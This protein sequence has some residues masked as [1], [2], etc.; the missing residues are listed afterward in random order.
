MIAH[1]LAFDNYYAEQKPD[2]KL[3]IV[4]KIGQKHPVAMIGDGINDAAAL[5]RADIGI[6][7]G[8]A[9]S[10][11]IQ[12]ADIVLLNSNLDKLKEALGVS[13]LTL[14][15]IKQNLF[16]AFGYNIIAIP[17]AVIGLVS[18]MWAALFMGMSDVVIIGN[19]LW[20]KRKLYK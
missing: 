9:T 15:T 17:L 10:V 5:T 13:K 1:E 20:L 7:M 12:A 14:T 3:Q 2:Q 4:E 8:D 6:S 11:S 18:P 19:S 16:W